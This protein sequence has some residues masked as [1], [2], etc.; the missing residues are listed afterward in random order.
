[1]TRCATSPM[2]YVWTSTRDYARLARLAVEGAGRVYT[3]VDVPPLP[4]WA[5]CRAPSWRGSTSCRRATPLRRLDELECAATEI[6][7][8]KRTTGRLPVWWAGLRAIKT[9]EWHGLSTERPALGRR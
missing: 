2:P 9:R 7:K 4:R 1:M 3:N 6:S 5:T 8:L